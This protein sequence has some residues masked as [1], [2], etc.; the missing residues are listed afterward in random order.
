ME[1]QEYY[2]IC[3]AIFS[4]I[5]FL[6]NLASFIYIKKSFDTSKCLY[7][8][9]SLDAMVVMT[10]ALM[11]MIMFSSATLQTNCDPWFCSVLF[12]ASQIT[13]LTSPMCNF[14]ISYIR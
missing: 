7:F 13:A 1:D 9:L 2:N 8:I 10:V 3:C 12:F 14:M 11:A 4:T 5:A 6:S